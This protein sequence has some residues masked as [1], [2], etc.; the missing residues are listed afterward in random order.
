[1]YVIERC[2]DKND[3]VWEMTDEKV[4]GTLFCFY[5]DCAEEV[6]CHLLTTHDFNLIMHATETLAI[7]LEDLCQFE[8]FENLL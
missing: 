4:L 5:L 1:M 7:M 3:L 8:S 2:Q 6:W